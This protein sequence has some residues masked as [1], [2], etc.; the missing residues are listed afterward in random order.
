MSTQ[1]P[2]L[3]V[4]DTKRLPLAVALDDCKLFPVIE[5]SWADASDAI[6]RVTPAAIVA[7]MT[8]APDTLVQSLAADCATQTP[9]MP[10]IGIDPGAAL[11][12]SVLPYASGRGFDG[13]LARL[14]AAMRVRTLAATVQR[15]I[16]DGAAAMMP[17]SDVLDDATVL[18][19]GRGASYPALSI[20]LGERVAVIGALSLEVAFKHLDAR[21]I[22]GIV[23]GAGF[24]ARMLDHFL[25]KLS[26]DARFRHL[27]VIV[28]GLTLDAAG[29][30]DLDNLEVCSGDAEH[31]A[32][33]AMPLVRQNALHARLVRSLKALESGGS[34]DAAT[35][36]MT[37]SAFS[38]EFARAI[39]DSAA[40]GA[41][42][43]AARFAFD[44]GSA[45]AR[46]DS[47]RILS[48]LMRRF[49]FATLC[50]DGTILAAFAETDLRQ[51]HVISR[52]IASVVKHT[53]HALKRDAPMEPHVSVATLLA[54]DT[55]ENIL[56]RLT[57]GD[58]RAAS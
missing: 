33:T 20:A 14:N 54:R 26:D 56:A 17:A 57:M 22:D 5:S 32:A 58:R 40:R 46:L 29:R 30:Y 27:P 51:A 39:A 48:R 36:L 7:D 38:D 6:A 19:I 15:R 24:S 28:S 50:A 23:I 9:Y 44:S 34:L 49:D 18:L 41:S 1:G 12:V 31:V 16:A 42:L 2:I 25:S 13:L 10:M 37:E 53:M 35:G 55:A 52:R 11:P 4:S 21:D 45:R 3:F 47:A 43:S 8:D